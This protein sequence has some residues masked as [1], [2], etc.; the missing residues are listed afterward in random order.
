MLVNLSL[1]THLRL[2]ELANTIFNRFVVGFRNFSKEIVYRSLLVLARLEHKTMTNAVKWMQTFAEIS[3][4][5]TPLKNPDNKS[6]M[7]QIV[8]LTNIFAGISPSELK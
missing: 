2:D 3:L 5:E 6:N 4:T 1:D 8:K 7:V